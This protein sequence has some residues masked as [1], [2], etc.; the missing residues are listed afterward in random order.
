MAVE[1]DMLTFWKQDFQLSAAVRRNNMATLLT[2][3][4]QLPY[5][6]LTRP[7]GTFF[8]V[9]LLKTCVRMGKKGIFH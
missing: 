1:L 6:G 9:C 7:C 4:Y 8:S 2:L 3:V 5:Q